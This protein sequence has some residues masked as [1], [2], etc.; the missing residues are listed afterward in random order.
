M[1]LSFSLKV[2]INLKGKEVWFVLLYIAKG[3]T[4]PL[5]L[6]NTLL[7]MMMPNEDVVKCL[8]EKF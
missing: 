4:R 6:G 5:K 1:N 3:R 7:Q 8:I 2:N